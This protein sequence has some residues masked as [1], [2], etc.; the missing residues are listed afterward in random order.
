[1]DAE[2]SGR[3]TSRLG[4][5]ERDNAFAQTLLIRFAHFAEWQAAFARHCTSP[6]KGGLYGNRIR[7]NEQILENWQQLAMQLARRN[8][9]DRQQ[10]F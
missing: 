8:Q 5:F 7:F 3:A 2:D 4:A 10:A 9:F 6:G 1:M